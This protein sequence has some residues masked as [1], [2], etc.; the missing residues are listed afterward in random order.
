[1][2]TT[3]TCDSCGASLNTG[4][5]TQV[6]VSGDGTVAGA[7]IDLCAACGDGI[8]KDAKVKKAKENFHKRMRP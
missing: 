4:S 1:M 8:E 5:I 7:M 6:I 3:R 2:A